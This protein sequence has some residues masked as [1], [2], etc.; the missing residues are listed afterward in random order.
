MY[1]GTSKWKFV[2]ITLSVNDS[3]IPS[4]KKK[5]AHWIENILLMCKKK[6]T[7]TDPYIWNTQIDRLIDPGKLKVK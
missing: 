5:F 6:Y 4:R 2:V 3:D 1:D 7:H